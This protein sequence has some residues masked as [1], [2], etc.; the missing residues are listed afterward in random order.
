MN[1]LILGGTRYIGVHLVKNLIKDGHNVTIATRGIAADDFG[2]AVN[3]VIIE[4]TDPDSINK[5][6][7]K[8][9]Y[10]VIY[11]NIAYSS[12]DVKYLLDYVDTN[13]YIMT[14]T[15]SVYS[16]FHKG[17]TENEFDPMNHKLVWC[18]RQDFL[19]DEIKR[20]AESALFQIYSHV[21]SVAV[22]FPFIIGE[23][24]YTKRL[25]FYV[26]NIIK[27]NPINIDNLD[28]EI[29]FISSDEAG[30]FLAW[31]IDKD[32][33][34]V[35]NAGSVGSISIR[36]MVDYVEKKTDK[37]AIITL[38]GLAAPFN[39]VPDFSINTNKAEEIGYDFTNLK[40]WIFDLLDKYIL[41]LG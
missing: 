41:Q 39:S 22:R 33:K 21:P 19:Y 25:F 30:K 11:D 14:S 15:L 10:D 31:L 34:G 12:N 38:D 2:K 1:I 17:I 3:R 9:H 5:R 13:R 32:F 20:Q 18:S 29:G 8:I 36:E 4:R 24:D 27:E 37:K 6:L 40:D 7:S 35:I 28:E 26:E 23:D 16:D